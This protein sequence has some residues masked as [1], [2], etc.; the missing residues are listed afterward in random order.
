MFGRRLVPAVVIALVLS[1]AVL[2]AGCTMERNAGGAPVGGPGIVTPAI[3]TPP[4]VTPAVPGALVTGSAA[5]PPETIRNA[6]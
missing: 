4:E 1:T 2:T 3:P 6:R 5:D